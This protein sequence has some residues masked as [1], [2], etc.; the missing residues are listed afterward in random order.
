MKMRINDLTFGYGAKPLFS[1]ITA[2]LEP[3]RLYTLAGPNGCGKSTL[4]KLLCNYLAPQQGEVWLNGKPI[5]QYSHLER[6]RKVGVVWQSAAPGLDFTVQEVVEIASSARFDRLG[7]L[8][9]AD[10]DSIYNALAHFGLQ[11]KRQ[12]SFATLSGGEK[13][14]VMLAG[15]MALTPEVLLLDEPT[16]ALDPANCRMV[17]DFITQYAQKHIVL[18][19]T[20]DLYIPC[21]GG[22]DL[23]LLDKSGNFY[24]GSCEKMLNSELLSKVYN[25][26]ATVECSSNGRKRVFFD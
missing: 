24:S 20:H 13:Q 16:S 7:K 10:K 25:T 18:V 2:T 15:A 3:G 19:I 21:H 17:A 1:G 4:L 5:A 8:S 23:W 14:Q 11:E 9:G 6:A 12:Q 26:P 22:G